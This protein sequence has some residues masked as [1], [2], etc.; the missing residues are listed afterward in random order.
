MKLTLVKVKGKVDLKRNNDSLLITGDG[1]SLPDDLATFYSNPI[2][3]DVMAIGRSIKMH[4]GEVKHWVNVDGPGSKWWA[5][6]LSG[7][8]LR[9]TLGDCEGYDCI[10]DDGRPDGEPWY[11]SSSLF[12][13]LI[14]LI[15]GYKAIILAGCPMDSEGHWYFGEEHK[16]PEWRGEDYEAWREF[17]RLPKPATVQSLSGFTKETL[18]ASKI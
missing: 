13:T 16:G 14:G 5:E 11:G 18:N 17:A 7:S 1:R 12:A 2:L 9:H 15:L 8:P 3:H 4:F 6:H 10:W